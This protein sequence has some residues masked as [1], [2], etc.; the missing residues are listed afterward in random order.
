MKSLNY[1]FSSVSNMYK[2][3]RFFLMIEKLGALPVIRGASLSLNI[4]TDALHD[5]LAALPSF[6]MVRL[7]NQDSL[8][9]SDTEL[10]EVTCMNRD[11]HI[12]LHFTVN[13]LSSSKADFVKETLTLLFK[14]VTFS[15]PGFMVDW[16]YATA[17]GIR[18]TR[19]EEQLNGTLLD[20][21]YPTITEGVH[22][23][24]DR[25]LSTDLPVLVVHGPPGTGKTRL[26]R[27]IL[28]EISQREKD[29][30]R[31]MFT[32]DEAILER[33][34]F[35]MRFVGSGHHALVIEDA[36]HLL[37]P[38]TDGNRT[39]HRFLTVSDGIVRAQ[40]RKIIFSSN[41]P[42]LGDLDDALLRPGRCFACVSLPRLNFGQVDSLIPALKLSDESALQIRRRLQAVGANSVSL[43]EVYSKALELTS[44]LLVHDNGASL[45]QSV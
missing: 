26:I 24:I 39:M 12:A 1:N 15:K 13:A 40:G 30:C 28:A 23:F 4:G 32:T 6:R 2:R 35:F 11:N 18:S 16:F 20:A 7:D 31:V 37:K 42:N 27:G 22:S 3:E 38:R 41:L 36:D 5:R 9:E 25:Y 44:G 34:E 29:D 14:D 43:A 10:V 8:L 17:E 33:D 19:I 45:A 21:A